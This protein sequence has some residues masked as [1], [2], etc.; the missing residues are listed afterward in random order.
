MSAFMRLLKLIGPFRWW[1]ALAVLLTFAVAGASVGLMATS[2]YLISKAAI[3]ASVADLSVALVF[4]RGFAVGRAALRYAERVVTHAATFRILTR[5]RVWFYAAIE[6]LAPARLQQV[7]SGD[8]LARISAD[9]ET[10]DNFYVRVVVPPLAAALVTL[11]ASA[12]LGWFNVWLG[13]ALLVFL[14]LAGIALP[15]A[16]RWLSRQPS[17]QLVASRAELNAALVD[18][19]QGGAD[20]LAFNQDQ[21]HRARTLE[22]SESLIHAQERLAT[23]RGMS[24][25][26]LALFTSLAGITVLAMAIPL[27]TGGQID[28]VFLATI[29]LA[30][31]VSFEAV[32]PLSIALQQLEAN[33]AAARRLFQLIDAPPV[34]SD[35]ARPLPRPADH[36]IEFRS[37]SFRYSQDDAPALDQVSFR[38]PS[39]GRLAIVG[40]S[41]AGKST[42][43]NLLLRFWDAQRG[44]ICVGG[45]DIRAYRGDD[46]RELLGVASQQVHL[47]N[48]TIR[49]NLLL[50]KG[51]ATEDQL[52]AACQAAQ[53]HDFIASLPTGYD[54]LV[55]ENGLK[56]S[57]G[58]R[59]RIAIARV[60]LK[61]APILILDEV[62]ANLDAL[63]ER[64]V[65]QAL[66]SF[67]A[68]R[69][70]LII[71]HRRA[72][73][74]HVDRIIALEQGRVVYE[75]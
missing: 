41:G 22:T 51:N 71:S 38:V 61:D 69:T 12:L 20:L 21:T 52:I 64:K 33:Q 29:P 63:T 16:T 15:L 59:Q 2:A 57:G 60:I 32:Q 11:L 24:N 4:V 48:G 26:L 42:V 53:I 35:P 28:G 54:T 58:E 44:Q 46:V 65:M 62:T 49:D 13:L 7:R 43:A 72:G 45:N 25:A 37:V 1:I 17:E 73:F 14:L 23:V 68:G 39:G 70:T 3:S 5:L 8:L 40:P 6:P 27:V 74:E 18:E 19:I 31:I 47:F 75:F 34:V 56:L 55:G 67:M 66:E 50:A 30:A 9:I 36:S 10:L